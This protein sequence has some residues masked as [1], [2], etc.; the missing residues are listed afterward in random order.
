MLLAGLALIT[1]VAGVGVTRNELNQN[2]A[3]YFAADMPYRQN[4]EWI[5]KHLSGVNNIQYSISAGAAQGI[6]APEYLQ[7]L[8]AFTDWLRAQDKVVSA[9]SFADVMKKLNKAMNDNDPQFYHLPS[10]QF[11][12]S[13]YLTLYEMSLPYG[14]GITNLINFDKSS[15]RVNISL[16]SLQIEKLSTSI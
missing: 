8:N 13:Q 16:L 12:A 10:E 1:L 11:I 9:T 3:E 5:D 15:S 4:I 7:N 6:S 14:M 2:T